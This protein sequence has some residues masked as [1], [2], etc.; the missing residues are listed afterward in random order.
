MTL[1]NKSFLQINICV[2]LLGGTALFAKLISLPADAITFFRSIFGCLVLVS[3]LIITRSSFRLK[4]RQDY[5]LIILTGL[6]TGA[7]WVA[8]FHAIQISTVAV[9]IISL[10]TFP[11]M[12]SFL[13]PLFDREMIRFGDIF[14]ASIVFVGI[15]LIVPKFELSNQT[16]AGVLWGITSAVLF[17][18][19]NITVRKKLG[20][21]SSITTMC[22]QLVIISIMLLPFVSFQDSLIVDNRLLLLVL[23]S[24][25]FTATPHV[26]LVAS[27]HHIKAAT[28]SLILC[29]HPVYSI[30]FASMLISE[31]PSFKVILGGVLIFGI[32]VYES[33]GVR[34]E[35]GNEK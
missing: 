31:T 29:L 22:Y 19:R 21:L 28:A 13:E 6:L 3:M 4:S 15:L 18:I 33:I 32:S 10:Y 24:V 16:T 23:L 11:I 1:V 30:L 8:Y 17:S 9:G 26:L 20:H 25:L 12:T 27:L 5:W 34:V 7:H 35:N 2:L 14:R